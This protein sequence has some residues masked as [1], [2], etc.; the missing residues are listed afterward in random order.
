[1]PSS[2]KAETIKDCECPKCF[3]VELNATLAKRLS[4]EAVLEAQIELQKNEIRLLREL[5]IQQWKKE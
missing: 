5:L 1:M 4:G 3:N 2:S